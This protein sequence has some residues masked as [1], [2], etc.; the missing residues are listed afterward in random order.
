MNKVVSRTVIGIAAIAMLWI[1]TAGIL[2]AMPAPS[3]TKSALALPA[4]PPPPTCRNSKTIECFR[5]RD[6]VLLS[7]R[8]YPGSTKQLVL[9]LHGL[10]GSAAAMDDTARRLRSATDAGV[11]SLDLRGNGQ[12][13]GR[14]GDLAYVG[15]YENDVADV[16]AALR[17]NHPGERLILAGYSMG[18]GIAMRYAARHTLPPVDGYLLFAPHLGDSSP[19]TRKILADPHEDP[20]IKLD[21]PRI[22]GL[23]MFNRIGFTGL[24]HLCTMYFNVKITGHL[25]CYRFNAMR[26]VAPDDYKAAL[27]ADAKPLLIVAGSNDEAF[28][29]KRYPDVVTLHHNGHALIVPGAT[30]DS[31]L[32]SPAAFIAITDWMR[33]NF[34][35]LQRGVAGHT[36]STMASKNE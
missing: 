8:S 1:V 30:H 21:I 24:N 11:V 28:I 25:V 13:P 31:I 10:G 33:L 36:G 2:V 7:A 15:Q 14:W 16:V 20:P 29:A 34:S 22:L 6:G 3:F 26:S 17:K 18:G 5:M 35:S 4:A 12:S 27:T 19:T 23:L 9:L 32:H